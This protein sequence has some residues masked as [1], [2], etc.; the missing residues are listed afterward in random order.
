[1][2]VGRVSGS[3]RNA[4]TE[5]ELKRLRADFPILATRVGRQPLAYFDNAATTQKPRVVIDTISNYYRKQN[6]NV[7][8]AAHHLAAEATLA[9]ETARARVARWLNVDARE[10]IWTRGTTE[11]INLVAQAF[12]A[13]RLEPGDSILL[14][15]SNH[16]ANIVPWQQLARRHR[17]ELLIVDLLPSG[18]IDLEQYHRLLKRQPKLVALTQV[19]NALGTIYPIKQMVE[20]ARKAGA[21]TLVD[22]AQA[23]PHFD[24]DLKHINPDFYAFSG[25][26]TFAPT[27][28]GVLYG[29]YELLEEMPPW[30]TGGEMIDSVSFTQTSFAPPPLRFE[31]GTPNICGALGLA[32]AIDYLERLDRHACEAHEQHLL[33]R[34][35]AGLQKLDG[36]SVLPAGECR[37][38]LLSCT[39]EK[40]QVA[41][42]AAYLDTLGIAVRAGN[43]CAQPLMQLLNVDA[44]LRISFAFYNTEQEVDRLLDALAEL[45]GG[46]TLDEAADL[47][48]ALQRVTEAA[49]WPSRFTALLHLGANLPAASADLR[50]P[51]WEITGCATRSWMRLERLTEGQ[52]HLETDADSRLMRGLLYLICAE[53]N[54]KRPDEIN[55]LRLEDKLVKMGFEAQ[56]SQTR[57]N[58]VRQ[59]LAHLRGLVATQ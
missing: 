11:S 26:K 23:Q 12:L 1:M 30:Q 14:M 13:E 57:G 4:M 28:I 53:V 3:D 21:W 51:E 54:S 40:H 39:F 31:A 47:S 56:L 49:D 29:R 44:S 59:I 58:A 10:I 37:V 48:N 24:V 42:V 27:G 33:E 9:Y 25:H 46:A 32:A 22:G 50:Q 19:S 36:V 6:A 5:Q 20:E 17:S 43:H 15:A 55:L 38:A 34:A 35:R 7:H 41:D 8:R 2:H 45:L 18:D 52:L 16:H